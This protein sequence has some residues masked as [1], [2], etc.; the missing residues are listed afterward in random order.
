EFLEKSMVV[1]PD[2]I[3]IILTGYTDVEAIIEAINKS[4]I[5][6]YVAKPGESENLRIT[7]H[8]AVEAFHLAR[9]NLRLVEELRRANERMAAENAYLSETTAHQM[10]HCSDV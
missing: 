3:R 4:R 10:T 9:E 8:R 6:R 5:Y 7:L 2:A 1:R